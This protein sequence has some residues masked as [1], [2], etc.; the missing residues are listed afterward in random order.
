MLAELDTTQ[1]QALAALAAAGDDAAVE[2]WRID[3]LGS[4]GQL[5]QL[6]ARMKDVEPSE[7]PA[8]GERMN[9]LKQA[10]E[11][12]FKAHKD[13]GAKGPSGPPMDVTE[14][15]LPAGLGRRHIVSQTVAEIIEVFARMGFE[16]TTGPEV[17]DEWHNFTALNVPESHPAREAIDNYYL[18]GGGIL[19]SQTSTVQIRVLEKTPPPVRIVAAGRV[20]RPDTHDATHYSMFHQVEGLYVDRGVTMVD[21]KSTLLGF[22]HAFFGEEVEV[23][24]RPS[25][26]PFTEPSAEVDMKMR[27]KGKWQWVELGG[28]GMVDP[29]V[30]EALNID[31]EEW[32]G[33]AF[34]L[35]VERVAMRKHGIA[36][37]RWLFE[38]DARFLR[39][40]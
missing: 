17:E 27:I 11:D 18:E 6:M 4:K 13:V 20:Y 15:G 16:P 35:G 10:L 37:I 34:G 21:L 9:A 40:F 25:F 14:P 32:T 12:A 23:R 22:A 26:F 24:M 38:N 28:C 7:R 30:L 2:A 3:W 8:F 33:F 29:N 39:Q 31:A 36:D 1:E 19:R 5:K